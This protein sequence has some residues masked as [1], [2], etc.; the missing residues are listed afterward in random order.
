MCGY[1]AD[2]SK[3]KGKIS[4]SLTDIDEILMGIA[5]MCKRIREQED[6]FRRNYKGDFKP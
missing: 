4:D 6:I 5:D 3:M 2:S 1:L